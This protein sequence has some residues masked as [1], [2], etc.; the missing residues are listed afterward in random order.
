MAVQYIHVD[1]TEDEQTQRRYY[2]CPGCQHRLPPVSGWLGR[3]QDAPRAY[4]G[5]VTCPR[6]FVTS[7]PGPHGTLDAGRVP[8]HVMP[9][10]TLKLLR[11]RIVIED[12]E[13]GIVHAQTQA[14]SLTC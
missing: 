11:V 14:P 3:R 9:D 2:L 13:A 5:P 10:G 6:C 12:P 8:V 1:H 4:V 7:V